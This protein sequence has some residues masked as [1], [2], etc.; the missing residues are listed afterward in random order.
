[1]PL[2]EIRSSGRPVYIIRERKGELSPCDFCYEALDAFSAA[3]HEIAVRN[4]LRLAICQ[5]CIRQ[6]QREAEK[7]VGK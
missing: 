1:M 3:G 5:G 4:G 2:T 6:L 7:A